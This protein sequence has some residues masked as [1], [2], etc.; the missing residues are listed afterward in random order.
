MLFSETEEYNGM[1]GIPN[2][3]WALQWM[4]KADIRFLHILQ[5]QLFNV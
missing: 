3:V 5:D 4:S 2:S 1:G